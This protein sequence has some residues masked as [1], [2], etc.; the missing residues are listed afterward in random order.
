MND[1]ERLV[2]LGDVVITHKTPNTRRMVEAARDFISRPRGILTLW[3]THG[4]AK[5]VVLQAI[6]NECIQAGI[7]AVYVP[8][9]HLDGWVR[10]AFEEHDSTGECGSAWVRYQKLCD[11]RV[12]AIDEFEKISETDWRNALRTNLIDCRHRGG[13]AG[14]CGTVIAMNRNPSELDSAIYSR[15]RDGRYTFGGHA[16]IIRNDDPDMRPLLKS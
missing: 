3:G 16:P 6:V 2:R 1:E 12:L 10:E 14:Q 11:V 4:N 9:F 15:M 13:L 8:F 7:P 5:T